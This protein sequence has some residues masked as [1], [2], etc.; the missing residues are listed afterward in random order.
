MGLGIQILPA[1][2]KNTI[3]QGRL[4]LTKSV[5]WIRTGRIRKPLSLAGALIG[6]F[7][8]YSFK[9]CIRIRNKSLFTV[10][11]FQKA[12]VPTWHTLADTVKV[13]QIGTGTGT[14]WPANRYRTGTYLSILTKASPLKKGSVVRGWRLSASSSGWRPSSASSPSTVAWWRWPAVL[15]YP[16]DLLVKRVGIVSESII[17]WNN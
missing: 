6:L 16:Q 4:P 2:V 10:Y 13:L 15:W 3:F 11:T 12:T 14:V 1:C 7:A 8:R 5:L 17:S 9:G